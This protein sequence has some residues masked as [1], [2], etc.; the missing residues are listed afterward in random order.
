[1]STNHIL[2]AR[3]L[4]RE[5]L[6]K[7]MPD[8]LNE[9]E[10]CSQYNATLADL[11]PGT[12]IKCR[13]GNVLP[14]PATRVML[15]KDDNDPL[16]EFI[17]ANFVSGFNQAKR[18][19]A[20]QGPLPNTI[21]DFWRMVWE[22]KSETVVMTTGLFEGG[23]KKCEMYWPDQLGAKIV[24]GTM[25]VCLVDVTNPTNYFSL[26]TITIANNKF[27]AEPKRTIKHCWYTAWPDHGVPESP[28]TVILFLRA[29]I[30]MTSASSAIVVHC[31]AGIG[32]TGT[33]IAID[34][35]MRALQADYRVVDIYGGLN[36]M[37]EER[38]GSIQTSVQYQFIHQALSEYLTPGLGHSMFGNN[39]PRQ[40]T[41]SRQSVYDYFG[42]SIRGSFPPFV[43]AIDK[44][45]AAEVEGLKLGD[46]ILSINGVDIGNLLHQECVDLIKDKTSL[47]LVAL[48]RVAY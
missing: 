32:R 5:N 10:N 24:Y 27:P 45:G 22:Y 25:E 17:N 42:F 37:R 36:K 38:G 6:G 15:P 1:M 26:S 31:S 20:T 41:V 12:K 14:T 7:T 33:F 28:A 18:F 8:I 23:R 43:N 35:G 9:F 16:S 4:R 34:V 39:K 40:L 3:D 44:G 21:A 30:S 2:E 47:K 29:V 11:P 48:S 19:I 13:Y 46:V